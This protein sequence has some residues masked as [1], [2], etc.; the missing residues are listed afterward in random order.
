MKKIVLSLLLPLMLLS[1]MKSE[2]SELIVYCGIT[3]AKPMTEIAT[4]FE[5][6]EILPVLAVE[7]HD[8]FAFSQRSFAVFGVHSCVLDYL[9]VWAP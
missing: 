4:R 6:R 9:T 2:A 1:A 8:G 3:M 5:A 7:K